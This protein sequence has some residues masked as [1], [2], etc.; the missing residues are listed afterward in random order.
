VS[1]RP[2]DSVVIQARER[3]LSSDVNTDS[4]EALRTA[5][6]I[7]RAQN[8][9]R[10]S[11]GASNSGLTLS[12]FL[13]D[14]FAVTAGAGLGISITD[15]IG[16]QLTAGQTQSAVGGVQGVNDLEDTKPLCLTAP[17]TI[18]LTPA[19]PVNPRIDIVEVRWRR[20]L[21]DPLSRLILDPGTGTF[22]PTLVDKNLE[23]CLDSITPTVDGAAEINVVTGVPGAVPV[24]PATTAGY[25][26]LAEVQVAALAVALTAANITDR[27]RYLAPNGTLHIGVNVSC[28]TA[29]M[30]ISAP[31]IAP[32]ITAPPGVVVVLA[33]SLVGFGGNRGLTC[34]IFPGGVLDADPTIRPAWAAQVHEGGAPL[35]ALPSIASTTPIYGNL[36]G[37]ITGVSVYPAGASVPVGTPF[38]ALEVVPT[39]WTGA[40]FDQTGLD[41]LLSIDIQC[42]IPVG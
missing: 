42:T 7:L 3:P 5:R 18:T 6:A 2:F 16:Y 14:S 1:N 19:D 22:V 13:G 10:A 15:G 4:S 41:A 34:Y 36:G 29:T 31:P 32:T 40:A 33:T 39:K 27:R 26:K 35:M 38:Y 23:Y 21:T 11:R 20:A 30:A 12:G 9:Y 25:V 8:R 28:V 17:K 37:A 24:A